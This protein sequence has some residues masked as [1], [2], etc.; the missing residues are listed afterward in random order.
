MNEPA[1][2]ITLIT[3]AVAGTV[4]LLA[5]LFSWGPELIAALGLVTSAWIGV[6]GEIIRMLVTPNGNVKLTQ[7]EYAALV[8]AGWMPGKRKLNQE[9]DLD[10]R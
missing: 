1:R 3:A 4:N 7:E 2:I 8:A 10:G 9:G 6:A 5:L